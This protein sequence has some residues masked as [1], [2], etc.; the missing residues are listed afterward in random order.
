MNPLLSP[1]GS[2][3]G[4]RLM[5][6]PMALANLGGSQN[7]GNSRACVREICGGLGERQWADGG[8]NGWYYVHM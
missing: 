7:K 2:R 1:L 6:T 5:V 4:S 8:E 3:D